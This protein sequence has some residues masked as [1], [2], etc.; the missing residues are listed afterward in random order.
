V[1]VFNT[2]LALLTA[3]VLFTFVFPSG[4]S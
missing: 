4:G 1:T 3:W 2:L